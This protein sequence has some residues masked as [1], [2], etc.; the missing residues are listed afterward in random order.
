MTAKMTK[1]ARAHLLAVVRGNLCACGQAGFDVDGA[2]E[3]E[4]C[5]R[6]KR[7]MQTGRTWNRRIRAERAFLEGP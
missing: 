5:Y 1:A 7:W 4:G 2:F 6:R 3:C